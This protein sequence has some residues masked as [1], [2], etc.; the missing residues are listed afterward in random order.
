MTAPLTGDHRGISIA[1]AVLRAFSTV[2]SYTVTEHRFVFMRARAGAHG[3]FAWS[4]GAGVA[5][6]S[7]AAATEHEVVV[8]HRGKIVWMRD[9]LTPDYRIC[10]GRSCVRYPDV[11]VLVDRHGQYFR[12]AGTRCYYRLTG[13]VPLHAGDPAYRIQ[14]FMLD[15]GHRPGQVLLNYDYQWDAHRRAGETDVISDA[16]A[17]VQS[18]QVDLLGYGTVPS[19]IFSFALRYP[20]TTPAQPQVRLCSS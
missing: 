8:T 17:L 16:T 12:F 20:R 2:T 4:W 15:P 19:F 1:H 10:S 5:P 14:G 7:W 18:G 13:T 6:H 3:F 11:Q 9:N